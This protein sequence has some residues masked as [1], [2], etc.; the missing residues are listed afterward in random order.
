MKRPKGMSESVMCELLNLGIEENEA[1]EAWKIIEKKLMGDK[2][3]DELPVNEQISDESH[4]LRS[5]EN[6]KRRKKILEKLE[7]EDI[8]VVYPNE[9]V[10]LLK[11]RATKKRR[12]QW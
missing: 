6:A 3:K 1:I 8:K 11:R 7:E 5:E 2:K 10:T 12:G 9:Q 4:R